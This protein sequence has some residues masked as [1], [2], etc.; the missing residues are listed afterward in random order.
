MDHETGE[1]TGW[2]YTNRYYT[3][4]SIIIILFEGLVNTSNLL[5][6]TSLVSHVSFRINDLTVT[7]DWDPRSTI[8]GPIDT[9]PCNSNWI[10][11]YKH[12][13]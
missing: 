9:N 7:E 6:Y 11:K 12:F 8:K 10:Y 2:S 13:V 4:I 3:H 5:S 1:R